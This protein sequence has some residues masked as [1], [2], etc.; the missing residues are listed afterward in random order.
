MS[1]KI[2]LLQVHFSNRQFENNRQD[3]KRKLRPN[4][5]PDLLKTECVM[6]TEC[7]EEVEVDSIQDEKEEENLHF[8]E[9]VELIICNGIFFTLNIELF[10]FC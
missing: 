10:L 1:F 8:N 7:K 6:V 4:A 3:G 9:R 5:V 2:I